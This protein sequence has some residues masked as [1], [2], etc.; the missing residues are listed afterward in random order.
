MHHVAQ[1]VCASPPL[2][3]ALAG[4]YNFSVSLNR[5]QYRE[6]PLTF[7]YYASPLLA[8]ASPASGP[9]AG[10]ALLTISG[11]HLGGSGSYYGGDD[12]YCR[13]G[14]ERPLASRCYL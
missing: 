6:P 1:V 7:V 13:F 3:G 14:D 2:D 9:A 5:Q 4:G 8:A 10:G 11:S 12:Y